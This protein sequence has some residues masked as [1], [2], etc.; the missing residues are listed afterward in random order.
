MAV[1]S[2]RPFSG[3]GRVRVQLDGRELLRQ[4]FVAGNRVYRHTLPA[5]RCG[6]ANTWCA[7]RWT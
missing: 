5:C 2:F 4:T 1:N 3:E 7:S 6:G